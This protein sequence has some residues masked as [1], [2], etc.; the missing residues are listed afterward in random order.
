M[1]TLPPTK[2]LDQRTFLL[3]ATIQEDPPATYTVQ[4]IE[5][6]DAQTAWAFHKLAPKAA[7]YTVRIAEDGTLECDCWAGLRHHVCKH[8]LLIL[9]I[10]VSFAPALKA[11]PRLCPRCHNLR[12]VPQGKEIIPCPVCCH[13]NTRLP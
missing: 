9:S 8:A 13:P 7:T 1:F 5:R 2:T 11:K 4:Q 3:A 10:A 6:R 12:Q